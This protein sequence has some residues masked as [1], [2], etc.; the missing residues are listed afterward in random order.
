M[1]NINS[2]LINLAIF[3]PDGNLPVWQRL[4]WPELLASS[5]VLA[6]YEV[7]GLNIDE[8]EHASALGEKL[9]ETPQVQ[10]PADEG[11]NFT[12]KCEI[13]AVGDSNVLLLLSSFFCSRFTLFWL[14]G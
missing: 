7:A 2:K 12:E 8:F 10:R 4:L 13:S 5:F 9:P 1:A 3:C 14:V 11:P 6:V